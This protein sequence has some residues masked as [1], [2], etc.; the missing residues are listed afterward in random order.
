MAK[1]TKAEER[2]RILAEILHLLHEAE[3]KLT[4]LAEEIDE[5]ELA[6]QGNF[7]HTD[8]YRAV[9][10]ADSSLSVATTGLTTLLEDLEG[11]DFN[12]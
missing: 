7:E 2:G 4:P 6:L 12:W 1:E 9:S 8:R 10:T 3:D 11:V 5:L